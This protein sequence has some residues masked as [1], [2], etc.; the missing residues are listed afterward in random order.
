M[1]LWHFTYCNKNLRQ[2]QFKKVA[3]ASCY[4]NKPKK[5]DCE[6]IVTT[7]PIEKLE[8]GCMDAMASLNPTNCGKL[9]AG[10]VRFCHPKLHLARHR[11]IWTPYSHQWLDTC[12]IYFKQVLIESGLKV[13]NTKDLRL[14]HNLVNIPWVLHQVLGLVPAWGE[15]WKA[16]CTTP[17]RGK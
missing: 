9:A 10:F 12:S 8:I 17:C 16:R 3:Q 6:L 2:G 13:P 7:M 1:R 15:V 11:C 5:P 4:Q 14:W